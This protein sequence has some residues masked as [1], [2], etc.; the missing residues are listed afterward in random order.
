MEDTLQRALEKT[1]ELLEDS[2]PDSDEIHRTK[3]LLYAAIER[4][5]LKAE[6]F[7]SL[8]RMLREI[9]ALVAQSGDFRPHERRMALLL[10]RDLWKRYGEEIGLE[11]AD[12]LLRPK[13]HAGVE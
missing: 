2:L 9:F 11:E 1:R 3:S 5:G 8:Q 13:L 6:R 7:L 4:T 12:K 10:L